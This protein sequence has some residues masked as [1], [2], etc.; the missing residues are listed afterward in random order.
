PGILRI[1]EG[2][3]ELVLERLLAEPLEHPRPV[4]IG[5]EIVRLALRRSLADAG[6]PVERIGERDVLPSIVRR[7][8]REVVRDLQIE[9]AVAEF[10]REPGSATAAAA[11]FV[12]E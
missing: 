11:D 9:H 8:P 12:T 6:G 5:G 2:D 1:G 7:G 3:V 4:F 10:L